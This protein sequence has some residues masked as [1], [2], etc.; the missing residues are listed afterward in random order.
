MNTDYKILIRITA[1]RLRPHLPVILHPNQFCGVQ[2]NSVFEAV[3]VVRDPI[4]YAEI[5][6]KPLCIVSIDFSAAFDKISHEYLHKVLSTHCFDDS[7]LQRIKR[8]Y[9]NATSEIQIN[10]FRSGQILIKRSV[11]QGC[12]FSML[13]YALCLNPLIQS[14]EKHLSGIKIGRRQTKTAVTAYVDDVT[15]YLTQVVDIPKMKEIL[16]RNE[17]A[18]GAKINM[19]K[20]R[21]MAIGN[22]DTTIQIMNIPYY[23]EIKILGF[24]FSNSV[25]SAAAESWSSVIAR[26]HATAQNTLL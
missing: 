18:T 9:D 6:K 21:A 10:G 17:T 14:L 7:F 5:S 1:E 16:L 19:L 2:G 13:L 3:V 20:S 15:I 24:H 25:N 4:A 8:L 23:K 11:R 26:V 12:P 22:W